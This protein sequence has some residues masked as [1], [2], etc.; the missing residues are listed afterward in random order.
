MRQQAMVT[1][2]D[3]PT[4]RNPVN[5]KSRPE[6]GPAKEEPRGNRADVKNGKRQDRHPVGLL[7]VGMYEGES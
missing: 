5:R 4:D 3:A 2:A 1:H 6:I 7:G